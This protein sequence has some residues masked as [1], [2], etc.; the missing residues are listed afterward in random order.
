[1]THSIVIENLSKQYRIGEL[2][3]DLI[4]ERLINWLKHPFRKNDRKKPETIWA[5]KDVSFTVEEGEVL[6]IIGRQWSRQEHAAQGSFQDHLSHFGE[7]RVNG[8]IAGLLEVGTGFHGELTG[9]ENIF[10][11]GSIWG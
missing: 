10:L 1:M 3:E 2:Q 7:I 9:R 11:N 4:Q 6:G 5:L 8:R